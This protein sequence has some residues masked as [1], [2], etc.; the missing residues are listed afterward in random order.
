MADFIR[1]R[2]DEQKEQRM[3]E[4]KR[5]TDE[6]F[7]EH[8]YHE[9]T[10]AAIAEQLGWSRAA[11]YKY[12]T[13]KEDIFLEI[14]SEKQDEY[15]G[16]LLTA[17]PAGSTYS[18]AVLT[19]V[20]VE[21]L[22]SHR[23]YLNYCDLLFTIIETNSAVERL[24]AFKRHYYK[25][26]DQLIARFAGNLGCDAAHASKLLNAVYYHAVGIN[27]WCQENPLVDEAVKLA[28][29]TRRTVDF[30]E[31]MRDFIGMC[32]AHYAAGA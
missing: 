24:A 22:A 16:A 23:D 15:Y 11:L 9:I 21:Q 7:A 4:I 26:Q 6:L 3:A 28:G 25:G 14:C 31:E 2:S 13:T 20:W 27:G 30:R 5:V 8:P 29:I 1:A 19:E 32:L 17:Y 18:P 10:L 12:V